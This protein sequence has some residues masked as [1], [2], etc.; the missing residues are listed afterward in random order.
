MSS[1]SELSKYRGNVVTPV[2]LNSNS[3]S[4]DGDGDGDGV[5]LCDLNGKPGSETN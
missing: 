1:Q 2:W 4:I 5:C 3:S